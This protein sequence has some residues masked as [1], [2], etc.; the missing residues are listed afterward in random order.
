MAVPKT[1]RTS[2]LAAG[3][4][5]P[6]TFAAEADR[7][8]LTPP[9]MRAVKQLAK[10]WKLKGEEV[11]S[12]LGVSSS[13][14]DRMNAGKWESALSQDQMTRVSAI[15]GVFKG[16]HLLFADDMADRWVRLRNKGPLF[17]NHAPIEAMIER[18]IPM[19]IEVRRHIDALRGGL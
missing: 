12:L 16:L 17:E 18:G 13:T 2:G 14:W 6:Q 4:P 9:A 7:K 11:G 3:S 15:V 5:F 1:N 19:M 10:H 8:R